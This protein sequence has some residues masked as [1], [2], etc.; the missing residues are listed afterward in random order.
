MIPDAIGGRYVL[1]VVLGYTISSGYTF[2]RTVA[3]GRI[4]SPVIE[5]SNQAG[6]RV[7]PAYFLTIVMKYDGKR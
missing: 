5:N 7:I 6:N 2:I 3:F 1:L 4:D